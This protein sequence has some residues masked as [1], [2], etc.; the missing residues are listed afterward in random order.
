MPLPLLWIVGV[1]ATAVAG[2]AAKK[3]SENDNSSTSSYDYE[4]ESRRREEAERDRKR[5]DK[6]DARKALKQEFLEIG[7]KYGEDIASTLNG[8]VSVSFTHEPAFRTKIGENIEIA[9]NLHTQLS[10]YFEGSYPNSILCFEKHC[11][12][13]T[14]QNLAFFI[15]NYATTL[16][17]EKQFNHLSNE[18]TEASIAIKQLKT[19][20]TKLMNLKNKLNSNGV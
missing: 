10:S 9:S 20:K 15:V 12:K 18:I 13:E 7:E 1:A 16:T 5:R 14:K 11:N 3:I 17:F 2:Y 6:R 8:I 19:K 4:E